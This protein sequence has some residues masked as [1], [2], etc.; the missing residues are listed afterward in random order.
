[1]RIFS[2]TPRAAV[3]SAV[4]MILGLGGAPA[5]AD[6]AAQAAARIA[7]QQYGGRVLKVEREEGAYRVKLLQPSG[8]VKIVR[9]PD[10]DPD[11]NGG[12]A[13][14]KESEDSGRGNRD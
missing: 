8:K 1:M 6:D 7:E 12:G 10:R 4:L 3:A 2:K 11:R 9:V 5:A 13:G 14:S